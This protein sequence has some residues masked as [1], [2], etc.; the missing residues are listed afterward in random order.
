MTFPAMSKSDPVA[1][2]AAGA[3]AKNSVQIGFEVIDTSSAASVLLPKRGVEL[4]PYKRTR[5]VY[6]PVRLRSRFSF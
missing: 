6:H 1:N 3:G 4:D 5:R 2:G